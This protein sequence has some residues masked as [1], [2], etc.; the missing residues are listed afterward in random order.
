MSD[1]ERRRGA[2]LDRLERLAAQLLQT[3]AALKAEVTAL[4]AGEQGEEERDRETI[5][6]IPD[7]P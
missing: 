7:W 3:A 2:K 5:S 6:S 1:A 4:R